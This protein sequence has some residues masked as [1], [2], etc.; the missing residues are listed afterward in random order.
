MKFTTNALALVAGALAGVLQPPPQMTPSAW[1]RTNLVVP[2]GPRAGELW[3]PALTP[4][5]IEPLDGLGADD[6][7]NKAVVRKSAQTGFTMLGIAWAGYM[8]ACAPCRMAV[9]QPTDLALSEFLRDK[10]NVAV[11]QTPALATRVYPQ[12]SRSGDGSTAY[13]KRYP[14]GS[15]SCLIAS[16]SNDL[17]SKTLKYVLKDEASAYPADLDGQGSPHKMIAARYTS[18]LAT[19]DWK[20]FSISTPVVAGECYIS[21]EFEAGDQRYWHVPCPHCGSEFYF[22]P[23]SSNFR[24]ERVYPFKAFYCAPCCGS[25]IHGHE[26]N[27]LV[28]KGRWIATAPGP[29]KFRSYHFDALSSPFVPWDWIANEI[30]T[31]GDDQS[32]LKTLWNMVFGRAYEFQTDTP[33]S[34][35][36]MERR[37]DFARGK[38]P[39][40]ALL[41]TGAADVQQRGI[42]YE[43]VAWAPNRESWVIDAGHID[44]DTSDAERGAFA[45]LAEVFGREYPDA[46]GHRRRVDLFGVDSG[47]R[48]NVVYAWTRRRPNAL[49]LDGRDGWS[50]PAISMAMPVDVTIDGKKIR[51]GASIRPVGTWSLKLGFYSDLAKSGRKSGAEADPD[52]YCHFADWL[53]EEYFRQITAEYLAEEIHRGRSRRVW[54][55]RSGQDNHLLDCRVY[56]MALATHLGLG[57]LTPE[58]WSHIARL[59]GVDMVME[60]GLFAPVSV[61]VAAAPVT[62]AA[63]PEP[64]SPPQAPAPDREGWLGPA[65][66]NWFSR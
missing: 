43:I 66:G 45:D 60:S 1:A 26:K 57:S 27:A 6:P 11:E 47:Y 41:L 52:G 35:R 12:Q 25:V 61:Q 24:F 22:D 55:V 31:A 32:K 21:E 64:S 13:T 65:K 19:G 5:I 9:V 50:R 40:R 3:D 8:I 54:K 39:P 23:T 51:K 10:F 20:E 42:W 14:G 7:M 63:P 59:H 30:I 62:A 49:A 58:Q 56:N 34:K 46:F 48:S 16:S 17:R 37:E 36:L 28:R 33:D 15:L 2:D 4:Y 44:G 38:I 18:Y 53:D 29:G